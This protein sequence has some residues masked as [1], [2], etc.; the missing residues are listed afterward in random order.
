MKKGINILLVLRTGGRYTI[1]E[2]LLLSNL[3][4]KHGKNVN[5]FC[6][7]DLFDFKVRILKINFIPLP[8]PEWKGWWSKMNMFN[9]VFDYLRPF[10]YVDLDTLILDEYE[11]IIPK[12]KNSFVTLEDFYRKGRL[13]SGLMWVGNNEKVRKIWKEW[14]ISPL[15]GVKTFYGDQEFIGSI[16]KADKYFQEYTSLIDSFKP[17]PGMKPIKEK[18]KDKAIICLHGKPGIAEVIKN[19]EWVKISI[20]ESLQDAREKL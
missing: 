18:P 2:V 15:L 17:L 4:R 8:N 5:I 10:L 20:I 19:Y 9:P 16:V 1:N 3:L 12:N 11:K 7:N 6:I 13:A 14:F